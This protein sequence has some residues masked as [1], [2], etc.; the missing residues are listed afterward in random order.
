MKKVILLAF[1]LAGCVDSA[2]ENAKFILA[3]KSHEFNPK[4]C[5]FLLQ[6][7]QSSVDSTNNAIA[8]SVGV[9]SAIGAANS[10]GRR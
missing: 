1:L 9:S 3:C 2:K 7:H 4:Q 5:E 8:V 10:V 6:M